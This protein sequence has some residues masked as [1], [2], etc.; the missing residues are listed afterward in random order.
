MTEL[1]TERTGPVLVIT[2]NRPDALNSLTPTMLNSIDQELRTAASDRSCR[3]VVLTGVGR[4][5][6][7]GIDVKGVA[8]RDAAAGKVDEVL[9]PVVAAF[10]NLH[11]GLSGVIRTIHGLPIPVISA[12]NGHAIGA[13]FAIA[14]ASDIRV[15]SDAA[16]FADGFVKRGISG[17]EMGLS[18]FLPKIVGPARAFEWMMTGRRIRAEEAERAGLISTVVP[19]EEL[20][21]SALAIG[22]QLAENAPMAVTMTKEVMWANLHASSLDHA[23]ALESRTQSLIRNTV[24]AQEARAAFL[25]KRDPAF[26][27][28][29]E[30]RPVR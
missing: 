16:A 14:A 26:S 29:T 23:L 9:D 30:P 11:H 25:E 2:F 7:A 4:A 28:P 5:F 6:C 27:N 15:G 19:Q 21:A 24:D 18:Y 8:A 22:E 20:V 12:V 10:E 17:C 1:L 13:G 3:A